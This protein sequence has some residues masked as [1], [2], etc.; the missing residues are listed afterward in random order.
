MAMIAITTSSSSNVNPD[1]FSVKV[2]QIGFAELLGTGNLRV[3][4]IRNRTNLMP[5]I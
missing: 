1:R 2:G 3:V 4:V 5:S